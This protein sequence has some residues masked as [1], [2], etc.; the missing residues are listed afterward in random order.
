MEEKAYWLALQK[1]VGLGPIKMQK[2]IQHFGSAQKVWEAH[3]L[4]LHEVRGI[5][6]KTVNNFLQ[7]RKS[8]SP[9]LELKEV[10]KKGI[11]ILLETDCAY[12]K[13]LREIYAFPPLLYIK[14]NLLPQDNNSLAVVGSRKATFYGLHMAEKLSEQLAQAKITVVSGLARGI[15]TAAHRGALKGGGRTIA[16]LGCGLD[17]PYPPENKKLA[18][19]IIEQ[20]ALISEFPLQTQPKPCNFPR[21]NRIISGLSLGVMVVEA[22]ARSG[23]LITADFALEQGR[24]VFALP[25]MITSSQSE[26]TN[27][28]IKQGAKLV[29]NIADILDEFGWKRILQ[30]ELRQMTLSEREQIILNLLDSQPKHIDEI[31][32]QTKWSLAEIFV[33]LTE[34]ELNNLIKQLPGKLFLRF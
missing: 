25:G 22:A 6:K 34:L 1:V 20:G 19:Q 28:L 11:D 5:D 21:R 29:Q 3:S 9:E 13:I 26:G 27:N 16:V 30:E 14:G 33:V 2:L 8:I 31:V 7:I 10:Q 17:I 15:D 4:D 18:Q 32:R 24:E 12:P 23:S